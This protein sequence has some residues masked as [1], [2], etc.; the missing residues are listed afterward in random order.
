M[1]PI[2]H[3]VPPLGRSTRLP[4]NRIPARRLPSAH[5]NV[6]VLYQLVDS[7]NWP[8]PTNAA[9]HRGGLF[10]VGQRVARSLPERWPAYL[11]RGKSLAVQGHCLALKGQRPCC[12]FLIGSGNGRQ[13]ARPCFVCRHVAVA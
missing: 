11:P 10:S 5:V 9:R 13:G 4:L 1:S 8:W 6:T 2:G 3:L 12:P 7:A